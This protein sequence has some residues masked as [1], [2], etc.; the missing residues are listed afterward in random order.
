[1]ERLIL[2][3]GGGHCKSCIEVIE[4]IGEFE[5][6]GIL[7]IPSKI[8]EKVL[9]YEI[10]GSDTDIATFVDIGIKNYIVTLG[11]I[12]TATLKKKIFENIYIQGGNPTSITSKYAIVSSRAK[13]GVGT[14]IMHGAIINAN[15][16]IGNNCIINNQANVEHDANIGNHVHVS[17]DAVIN[18][19]V[20][21]GDE[22]LIGSNS[23]IRN[24]INICSNVVI[25]AGSVVTKDIVESGTY[26]GNPIKRI[27]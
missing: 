20:N 26:V 24:G 14:I 16:K 17:T 12:H 27:K 6:A 22:V 5:I 7:D 23:V 3:G 8:G 2:I 10:I 21:I 13:I 19:Q 4:S 15:A 11:Q 18:G 25:G 9:N 1:M